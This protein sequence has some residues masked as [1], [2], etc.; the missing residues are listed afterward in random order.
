MGNVVGDFLFLVVSF[1]VHPVRF[2]RDWS[3]R[4]DFLATTDE[5]D[6]TVDDK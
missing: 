3:H 6:F 5:W 2:V 1:L 4:N